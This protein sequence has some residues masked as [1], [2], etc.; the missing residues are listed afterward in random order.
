MVSLKRVGRFLR[1]QPRCPVLFEWQHPG[2]KVEIYSDSDWAGDKSTRR[3]VSGGA[4]MHG[5]HLIRT[6]SKQQTV[7]AVSSAEAELYAASR[8]GSEGLGL[9]TWMGDLGW[10]V[11]V[12]LHMDSASA[13]SLI[14]REGL[15]KA[16]HIEIQY[17]WLQEAIRRRRLVGVKVAGEAN[18][19][20]LM[21]KHLCSER[22]RFLQN[23]LGHWYI[24]GRIGG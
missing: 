17:L 6:W 14:K 12:Q 4:L 22:M 1:G 10:R 9:Q 15:G 16:K 21:T 7:V 24:E 19:S 20:D 18:P 23:L 3:S 5:Q 8:A 2:A 11:D 13:L